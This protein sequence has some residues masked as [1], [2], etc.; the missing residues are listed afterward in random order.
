MTVIAALHDPLTILMADDLA[1]VV[2]PDNDRTNGWA[3]G[4]WSVVSPRSGKIEWRSG[5]AADL[6]AHIPSA[7]G[8]RPAGIVGM[9]PISVVVM[10][11]VV[12]VAIVVMMMMVVVTWSSLGARCKQAN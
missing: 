2:T 4:I 8:S 6:R 11:I 3:A 10:V 12:M 9:T 7:P 1:N 5:I